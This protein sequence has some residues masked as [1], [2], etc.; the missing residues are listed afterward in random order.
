MDGSKVKEE[1]VELIKTKSKLKR[2]VFEL[3][4]QRFKEL[5][6]CLNEVITEL[7]A[8]VSSI[9]PR[10]EISYKDLGEYYAQITIAGDTLMFVLH[11]NVFFF[12]DTSQHWNSSYLKH[13][14][15][16]GYCG[17]I[18]VY[19][20]LADSIRYNREKDA[21]YLIARLFLNMENH[22]FV[23]GKK[24]LSL[25][26]NNFM[27]DELTHDR[28]KDFIILVIRHSINF[29][30]FVPKYQ[31][32]QKLSLGEANTLKDSIS[33]KT[34]KRLGFQFGLEEES[35]EA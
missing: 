31:T 17:N 4:K 32:I 35:F 3:S 12:P 25:V 34:G 30:L 29:D 23:E 16:R 5:K 11:T 8:E 21:G 33:L 1:V 9:D 18:Q 19:N 7:S 14:V 27:H 15:N 26:F 20:F 24:E 28:M 13:D 10:L 2:D 22:F 6:T